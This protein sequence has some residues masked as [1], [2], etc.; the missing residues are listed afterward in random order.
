MTDFVF[1]L[2]LVALSVTAIWLPLSR[3]ALAK[4]VSR[5]SLVSEWLALAAVVGFALGVT[6]V[7]SGA[8]A[9]P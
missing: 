2:L 9:H 1:G 6:F 8:F 5:R 3:P 4:W 7:I